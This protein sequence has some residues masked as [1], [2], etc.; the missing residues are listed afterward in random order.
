MVQVLLKSGFEV[1]FVKKYD[2]AG[3][4]VFEDFRLSVLRQDAKRSTH[5]LTIH[6]K[7]S[8]TKRTKQ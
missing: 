4:H 1:N 8:Q 7:Q 5:K 2:I 3:W 6:R